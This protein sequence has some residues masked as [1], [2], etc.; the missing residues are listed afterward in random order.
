MLIS[1]N[2]LLYQ[3]WTADISFFLKKNSVELASRSSEFC[4]VSREEWSVFWAT[5]RSASVQAELQKSVMDESCGRYRR[6]ARLLFSS[7]ALSVLENGRTHTRIYP[8]AF[9]P[10]LAP[11]TELSHQNL[12]LSNEKLKLFEISTRCY[13]MWNF[14]SFK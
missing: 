5:F 11:M 2:F 12:S 9:H 6:C 8:Q 3:G 14:I 4:F 10:T 1:V 13:F 7:I